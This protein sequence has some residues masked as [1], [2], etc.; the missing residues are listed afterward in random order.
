MLSD[1]PG[2]PERQRIDRWLH[3][4][5][6]VKSRTM[7]AR[8]AVGGKVRINGEKTHHASQL[9]KP[10]DVL[11]L[12]L[13]TRILVY[14]VLQAGSRR[15]PASEARLLYEDLSPAEEQGASIPIAGRNRGSGRPTKKD[16][17]AIDRI[18]PD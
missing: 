2:A 13:E 5:R 15:G 14:R 6:V 18:L 4:A 3:F 12:A 17:R 11:T 10:G 9:I 16:R 1:P 7:A 8:L